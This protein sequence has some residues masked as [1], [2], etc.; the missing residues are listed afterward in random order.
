MWPGGSSACLTDKEPE[1]RRGSDWPKATEQ[2]TG[3]SQE[4]GGG[5]CH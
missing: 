1:T 5:S 3:H 4:G 2:A